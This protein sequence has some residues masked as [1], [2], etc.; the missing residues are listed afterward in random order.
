MRF[1][2]V[3][4]YMGGL[5]EINPLSGVAYVLSRAVE[6]GRVSRPSA[7]T[8]MSKAGAGARAV[9]VVT[10]A[11]VHVP[12]QVGDG[13]AGDLE[14]LDDRVPAQVDDRPG[15]FRVA[16]GYAV[17]VQLLLHIGLSRDSAS[18][19]HQLA[20]FQSALPRLLTLGGAAAVL[21]RPFRH[22]F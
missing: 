17:T 14:G 9:I 12:G 2:Q 7:T 10:I 1:G 20:E 8:L 22:Y 19:R 3:R 5:G 4:A 21:P 16:G 15:V 13:G 6:L 11:S 18:R